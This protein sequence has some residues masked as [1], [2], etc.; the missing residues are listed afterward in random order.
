MALNK[1]DPLNTQ[2]RIT[3]E[4]GTPSSFLLR[5]WQL[6]RTF[7][8]GAVD[9]LAGLLAAVLRIDSTTITGG[10][11]LGGGGAIGAGDQVITH[12]NSTVTPA[13]YTNANITVDQYG[14]V[15]AASNG[16]AGGGLE[17]TLVGSHDFAATPQATAVF[18]GLDY[19]ELLAVFVNSTSG[20]SGVPIVRVSTDNGATY[21]ATSGNYVAIP[22]TSTPSNQD[23]LGGGSSAATTARSCSAHITQANQT[24]AL[25][26]AITNA[27]SAVYFAGS[28]APIDAIQFLRSGAGPPTIT[29][30][31][32]YLYGR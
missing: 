12:D 22:A 21:Y 4:G 23:A 28:T 31:I 24:S 20:T 30:G 1:V 19:A 9:N 15:T 6:I 8:N 7:V 25:K 16:S 29:G 11:V 3:E 2:S 5:Q 10:G 17:W 18:T 14:H 32:A 26:M 13:S 27:F